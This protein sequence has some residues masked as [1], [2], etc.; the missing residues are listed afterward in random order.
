MELEGE[1]EKRQCMV[2]ELKQQLYQIKPDLPEDLLTIMS[3]YQHFNN[4]STTI[5]FFLLKAVSLIIK[6][7]DIWSPFVF[8]TP[9]KKLLFL[10]FQSEPEKKNETHKGS[11]IFQYFSEM[12]GRYFLRTLF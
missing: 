11:L 12:N 4:S 3:V 2:D 7:W 5:N 10:D 6:V 1:L 8:R 9:Y